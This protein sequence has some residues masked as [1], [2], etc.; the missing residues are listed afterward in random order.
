MANK[1][2]LVPMDL[3]K[4]LLTTTKKDNDM[5]DLKE[6]AP[7][8]YETQ[9]LK[10]IKRKPRKNA[11]AK[12]VLY[13][14]QFRR[15]LRA[16]NEAKSKPIK[17]QFED[18]KILARP[19][20]NAGVKAVQVGDEGDLDEVFVKE[21]RPTV[22]F[23]SDADDEASSGETPSRSSKRSSTKTSASSL[24][25]VIEPTPLKAGT[26]T[27]IQPFK[28]PSPSTKSPI[29][30]KRQSRALKTQKIKENEAKRDLLID[31]IMQNP[32]TFGVKGKQII[33][34]Q[35]GKAVEKSDLKWS[36]DHLIEPSYAGS[37]PGI[38]YLKKKVLAHEVARQVIHPKHLQK[39]E[40]KYRP[41]KW[42]R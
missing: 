12:N 21:K 23:S 9:Q 40:G 24:S 7:L 30:A 6:R 15:Y 17:V 8:H 13:Q 10:K 39:G 31:L 33:N 35:T 37:P 2:V 19:E 27:A 32:I 16:R 11:S 38:K 34:P 1:L 29:T 26:S 36:I 41:I 25:S 18:M 5:E 3:Y 28:T 4:G 22:R 14:Q 42:T 20:K